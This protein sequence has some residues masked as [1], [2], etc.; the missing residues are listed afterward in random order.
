MRI[1]E[2]CD[3]LQLSRKN[4]S[5]SPTKVFYETFWDSRISS[6]STLGVQILNPLV[7][8][9]PVRHLEYDHPHL[10]LVLYSHRR[11]N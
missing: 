7:L 4:P 8:V 2:Q 1:G 3:L 5:D 9:K 6:M 10:V 11:T